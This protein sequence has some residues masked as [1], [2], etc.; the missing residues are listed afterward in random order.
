LAFL[1]IGIKVQNRRYFLLL[2]SVLLLL[3]IPTNLLVLVAGRY[4]AQSQDPTLYLTREEKDAYNWIEDNTASNVIILAAPETG[5]FIPAH[6]GRRV[7]YGHPFE[8]VNAEEMEALV[9][10]FFKG[11]TQ[12][13]DLIEIQKADFLYFG[14]RERELGGLPPSL[15]YSIVYQNKSVTIYKMRE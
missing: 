5:L 7:L 2:G 1:W 9:T 6:T 15:E 8:T 10:R 4:G 12:K 11:E 13:D 3:S 14:L